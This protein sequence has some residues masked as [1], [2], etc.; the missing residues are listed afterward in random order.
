MFDL[1]TF[2]VVGDTAVL[3]F[4]SYLKVVLVGVAFGH[5]V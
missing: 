1:S 5:S 4:V 3:D 2:K